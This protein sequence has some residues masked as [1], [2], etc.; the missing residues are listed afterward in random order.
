VARALGWVGFFLHLVMGV[1]Y[2]FSG[3]VAPAWAV[4]VL[5]AI[6]VLITVATWRLL[7]GRPALVLAVPVADLAIWLAL[8]TAGGAF[9]NWSA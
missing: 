1:W 8:V 7:R 2:A 5:M 4:V 6:W 3:L 9:L